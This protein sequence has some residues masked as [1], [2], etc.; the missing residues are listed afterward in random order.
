MRRTLPALI[1]LAVIAGAA[2][3]GCSSSTVG[4]SS[5]CTVKSGGGSESIRA[6]GAFGKDP[7][8]KVPSPLNVKKAQSTTLITG[9]GKK[10]GTGGVAEVY[11]T[12][13]DG[14]TG[15]LG[16]QTSA[17]LV[18]V[19]SKSLGAGLADAISCATVGSRLA[20]VL[21]PKEA[22]LF[23]APSGD[24]LAAIVDISSAY[25]DR[26]T[27]SRR[28]ATPGFP[29]VVLAPN[30]QPGIVLGSHDEPTKVK[31]AVLKQGDGAVAK[32]SDSLIVQTQTVNWSDPQT[33]S[34]TW[35][36]GS[37]TAQTLSDGSALSQ[38]LIGKKVGSQII[39]LLP[40]S[41]S[42]S[43]QASATVV[44]ILG[45]LPGTAQQ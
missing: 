19:T 6:T 2:L 12:L 44:D 25:P 37:A 20:V 9:D 16:A 45:R 42:D 32:K 17:N 4:A 38:A 18:P 40:A 11:L 31:T 10:V 34:G 5:D 29:T 27:G 36:N 15:Q 24:S 43:G 13:F 23:N 41:K 8:A 30:G 3:T 39:V 33:A 28:A 21:P 22:A 35:E 26:A 14:A 7:E 1:A